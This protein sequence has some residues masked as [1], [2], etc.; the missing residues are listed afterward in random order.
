VGERHAEVLVGIDGSAIDANFVVEVWAGGTAALADVSDDITALDSLARGYGEAGEVA[1]ARADAASMVHHD[2]LAV[3]AQGF[4]CDYDSIRGCNDLLAVRAANINP[5][6]ECAF[7]VKWI[8]ALAEAARD[9]PFHRPDVRG[10]V[11]PDPISRRGVASEPHRKADH[12]RAGQRRGPQGV[13]LIQRR[14]DIRLMD[15]VAASSDHDGLRFQSIQGRNFTGNRAQRCHLHVTLFGNLF[16]AGVARLQLILLGPQL[17]ELR[18]L[19]EHASVR[20]GNSGQAEESNGSA[21]GKNI[22]V[23]NGNGDFAKRAVVPASDKKDVEAFLQKSFPLVEASGPEFQ[24]KFLE[25][26][27]ACSGHLT[28]SGSVPY[29]GKGTDCALFSTGTPT[30]T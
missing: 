5:A 7:A 20:A 3:A 24:A 15:L 29:L 22:E 16:Q 13:Q 12:R 26:K 4:G 25:C 11:G 10:R 18:N 1:I 8:D 6:V 14:S 17:V 2:D 21:D 19:Q 9:L 27:K 23:M 28:F 30:R